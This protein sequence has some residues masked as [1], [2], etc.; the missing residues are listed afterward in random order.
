[1]ADADA[2]LEATE[3]LHTLLSV[4][5]VENKSLP[6]NVATATVIDDSNVLWH[7]PVHGI[8]TTYEHG[9]RVILQPELSSS[10]NQDQVSHS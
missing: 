4:E 6:S 1:M 3:V 8:Q 9:D 10:C 7:I 5:R 2:E